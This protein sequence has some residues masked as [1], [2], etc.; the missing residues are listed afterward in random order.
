MYNKK[1]F[2][3]VEIMITVTVVL[4]LAAIALPTMVTHIN[5]ARGRACL[6]NLKEIDNAKSLYALDN[7]LAPGAPCS[8]N[9]LVP[10]YMQ[11]DPICTAGGVYAPENVDAASGPTCSAGGHGSLQN[12]L[13][14][15]PRWTALR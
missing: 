9:D 15:P 5:R 1:G 10:L 11:R 2:S 13:A 8:M 7:N 14:V 6:M 12:G 3:L 4:M